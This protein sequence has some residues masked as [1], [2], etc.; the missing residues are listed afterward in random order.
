MR[1]SLCSE[2]SIIRALWDQ[3][4]SKGSGSVIFTSL[5]TAL[6][7]LAME[8]PALLGMEPLMFGI[9]VTTAAAGDATSTYGIDVSAVS[10]SLVSGAANMV[11]MAGTGGGLSVYASAMK[12]QW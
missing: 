2:V 6:K 12:L 9:G 1:N 11:G 7:R 8:K 5:V 10:A 4:D 3:Y